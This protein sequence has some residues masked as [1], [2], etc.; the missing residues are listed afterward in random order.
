MKKLTKL[1]AL[2]ALL[3]L[4]NNCGAQTRPHVTEI[5]SIE[6]MDALKA[7][8]PSINGTWA[9]LRGYSYEGDGGGGN[10]RWDADATDTT[11][12][13]LII[14]ATGI[15][16]GRWK[17]D[18][19]ET[20]EYKAEWW[21]A[22]PG[23]SCAAEMQKAIDATAG[24][25]ILRLPVGAFTIDTTLTMP[26]VGASNKPFII[27][28]SG[29][30][31]GESL[32][33]TVL[34]YTGATGTSLLDVSN[35]GASTDLKMGILS[36][37]YFVGLGSGAEQIAI[38][39]GDFRTGQIIN[40]TFE[41]FKYGLTS[42]LSIG[43]C[44]SYYSLIDSCIFKACTFGVYWQ[45]KWN[46]T[47]IRN[48]QFS[49]CDN[50]F[51]LDYGDSGPV[52]DACY[53]ES[54]GKDVTV[55]YAGKLVCRNSYFGLNRG[56]ELIR[57]YPTKYAGANSAVLIDGCFFQ[58][59]DQTILDIYA[60]NGE[61]ATQSSAICTMISNTVNNSLTA[62]AT[63]IAVST[64]ASVSFKHAVLIGNTYLFPNNIKLDYMGTVSHESRINRVADGQSNVWSLGKAWSPTVDLASTTTSSTTQEKNN[65][66]MLRFY[67]E[68]F[69]GYAS[70]TIG[71]E[72]LN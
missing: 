33:K 5:I 4:G 19:S 54:C 50:G 35:G 24:I 41:D 67:N 30:L 59:T 48:T 45:G 72:A 68:K 6:D 39:T 2:F 32:G 16:T 7:L 43:S 13:G 60:T 65:P 28:G 3:L 58:V 9:Y 8:K 66:G 56:S 64:G 14:E 1:F 52:F 42:D 12:D 20:T 36:D 21:G 40:C 29:G 10:F 51:W 26:V 70:S 17:R 25:G 38:S 55:R 63:M 53:F 46:S 22:I 47:T 61:V 11:D 31:R 27:K 15:T 34:Y 57:F 37:I 23:T 69:E 49:N 18:L 44:L 62:S 71:W